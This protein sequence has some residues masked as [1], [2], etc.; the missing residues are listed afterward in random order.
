MELINKLERIVLGWVK[1]IPHLP[2]TAQKWLGANVWWIVLIGAIIGGIW[3]L[4]ALN[5]LFISFALLNSISNSYYVINDLAG[6]T[7]FKGIVGLV[8]L[9]LAVAA[10]AFAV[11]PLKDQQKKGWV[12]LFTSWLISAISIVVSAI[13]SLSVIG[14][15][16]SIIFGAI[17]L[18]I[19][20]YFLFG[21]HGQFAHPAKRAKKV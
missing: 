16:I 10:L 8:L 9:G 15:I 11:M 12:L 7:I 13:L 4:F 2:A 14:F 19:G 17:F 3:F 1:N 20:G 18:A 6:Y 5:S 21:I